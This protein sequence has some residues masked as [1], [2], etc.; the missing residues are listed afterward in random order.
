M[1]DCAPTLYSLTAGEISPKTI[2]S[3]IKIKN[4][5]DKSIAAPLFIFTF[6]KYL[7]ILITPAQDGGII[8]IQITVLSIVVRPNCD[9]QHDRATHGGT[10][11]GESYRGDGYFG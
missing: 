2:A 8:E 9:G 3:E 7:A 1:T 5:T 6:L 4:T 10:N 11:L